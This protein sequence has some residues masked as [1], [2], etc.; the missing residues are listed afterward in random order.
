MD[1]SRFQW[2]IGYKKIK[3]I[4]LDW[5]SPDKM[6]TMQYLKVTYASI[7]VFICFKALDIFFSF[8]EI[9]SHISFGRPLLRVPK[10][11]LFELQ[12]I[13][14]IS[15]TIHY[16][17]GKHKTDDI[18]VSSFVF[19]KSKSQSIIKKTSSQDFLSQK[20]ELFVYI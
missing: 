5:L 4:Y 16:P 14:L 10:Y 19:M 1:L 13:L 2:S 11:H 6:H 17:P 3:S 7:R 9:D 8:E 18:H 15:I 20:I 12:I